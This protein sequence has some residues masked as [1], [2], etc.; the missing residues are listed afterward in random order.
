MSANEANNP[1]MA[2]TATSST[3]VNPLRTGLATFIE[4]TKQITP[5]YYQKLLLRIS[6]WIIVYQLSY[7]ALHI[8]LP[9]K[10]Y[11]AIEQNAAQSGFR[12]NARTDVAKGLVL[13]AAH[14]RWSANA[15]QTVGW[16]GK[17]WAECLYAGML[18]LHGAGVLPLWYSHRKRPTFWKASFLHLNNGME[19]LCFPL[20]GP[21][22]CLG[23][24]ILIW[25]CRKTVAAAT[26]VAD[27]PNPVTIAR[28]VNDHRQ[29]PS[30]AAPV[31]SGQA[32]RCGAQGEAPATAEL[33]AQTEQTCKASTT[34]PAPSA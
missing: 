26:R 12:V 18:L 30:C 11:R 34:S 19:L 14:L 10:L 2:T 31:V 9:D 32:G 6:L 33:A 29:A 28:P 4:W 13:L 24:V 15:R 1:K 7:F 23:Y 16:I 27:A 22:L 20:I 8:F 25:R 5:Q 17:H 21:L 3:K